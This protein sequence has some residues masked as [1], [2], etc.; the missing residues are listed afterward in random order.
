MPDKAVIFDM[1][2]VLIDSYRAHLKAWMM[3][4]ERLGRP[5]TEEQFVPTFGR[6]NREIF[7]HLWG[8]DVPDDQ[9]DQWGDWKEEAYRRIIEQDFP[10]MDG[11]AELID[12][13]KAAGF[14]LAIGSSGP[15]QNV[16]AALR[17]LGRADAF[18]AIVNGR[19]VAQGKPHPEVFLK[20]A[21][22]LGI[23]PGRCAVVE[24]ALAGLEAARRAG[25]TPIAVTGTFPRERL[26]DH[27]AL[28]V[29]SLRD[30]G[31]ERIADLI[32]ANR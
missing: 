10:A 16:E 25:M 3:L 26:K 20:A 4:G 29:D 9:I 8:D 7:H 27:A 28:V 18:A 22:K 12:A 24:D 5:I 30:L 21:A 32:D 13:L 15:P 23:Q 17:G 14:A 31:P 11:A 19:E 2:G 1:D 6:R